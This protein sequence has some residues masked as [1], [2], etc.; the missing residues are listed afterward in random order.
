M[1]KFKNKWQSF[2]LVD[3]DNTDCDAVFIHTPNPYESSFPMKINAGKISRSNT[4]YADIIHDFKRYGYNAYKAKGCH[5]IMAYPQ[6]LTSHYT[7]ECHE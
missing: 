2:I 7:G 6:S 1:T 5:S 3:T 4:V